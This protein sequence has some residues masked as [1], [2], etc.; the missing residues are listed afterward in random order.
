MNILSSRLFVAALYAVFCT[1]VVGYAAGVQPPAPSPASPIPLR[2]VI[3]ITDYDGTPF[4]NLPLSVRLSGPSPGHELGVTNAQGELT[5]TFYGHR[6][7]P[8]QWYVN[9]SKV[10]QAL[11]PAQLEAANVWKGERE[12]MHSLAT[13][14]ETLP[15]SG[16][17]LVNV[18]LRNKATATGRVELVTPAGARLLSRR[19]IYIT[20]LG[21]GVP[22]VDENPDGSL[23]LVGLGAAPALDLILVYGPQIKPLRLNTSS[24]TTDWG[25]VQFKEAPSDAGTLVLTATNIPPWED[26]NNRPALW[27]VQSLRGMLVDPARKVVWKIELRQGA[28]SFT[29][30]H[31]PNEP[32]RLAPGTYRLSISSEFNWMMSSLYE[33]RNFD[34]QVYPE[35]VI[36]ANGTTSFVVDWPIQLG[37]ERAFGLQQNWPLSPEPITSPPRNPRP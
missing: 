14:Q 31:K 20:N 17:I 23:K 2:M 3:K 12:S 21:L 4:A 5:V 28:T 16:P 36:P 26:T 29:I 1:A 32:L 11:T 33:G 6:V 10:G 37:R 13:A 34:A 35:I 27:P 25:T 9:V 24:G 30:Q 19:E 7:G 8:Y 18:T 22:G 15:R